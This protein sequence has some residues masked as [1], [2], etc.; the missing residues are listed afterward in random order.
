MDDKKKKRKIN[1]VIVL[2]FVLAL[3]LLAKPA[4][5]FFSAL[6]SDERAAG[7]SE[8]AAIIIC[9]II[10]IVFL[11]ALS[12]ILAVLRCPVGG[13]SLLIA[14]AAVVCGAA[15]WLG[16]KSMPEPAAPVHA[17]PRP[18]VTPPVV[19]IST[20]PKANTNPENGTVF[21]RRYG[22]ERANLHIENYSL[23]DMYYK[24]VDKHGLLV[25]VFYVRAREGCTVTVPTGTYQ[26]LC[27]TGKKWENE[28]TFFGENSYYRKLPEK[29]VFYD[30]QT[31]NITLS[32]GLPE[33]NNIKAK[34]FLILTSD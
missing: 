22:N 4:V 23:S 14:C 20:A 24:M 3:A 31:V 19:E 13:T 2:V 34:E 18:T 30:D 25:L 1:T 10:V 29:Y 8:F 21:Y 32:S 28:E 12:G 11:T 17:T 6:I 33:M 15:L 27:V 7:T 26:L 9:G 5:R 16:V